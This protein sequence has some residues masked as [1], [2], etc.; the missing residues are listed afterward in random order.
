MSWYLDPDGQERLALETELLALDYPQMQVLVCEDGKVRVA[1]YLHPELCQRPY[2][3]V[4]EYP[5]YYPYDRIK[6]HCPET[7]F[8]AGTPHRHMED[9][10][11]VDHQDFEPDDTICT[12]LG[13]TAQWLTL[14]E[15]YLRTQRTW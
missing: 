8:A 2:Y 15:D 3:V 4:L 11:C 9:D 1:G 14:Y 13:W 5:D 12:V 7:E 10:L 6:V